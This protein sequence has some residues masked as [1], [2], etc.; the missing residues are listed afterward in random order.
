MSVNNKENISLILKNAT[1]II[2]KHAYILKIFF[3]GTFIEVK[4]TILSY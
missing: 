3:F 1:A 4:R 2:S